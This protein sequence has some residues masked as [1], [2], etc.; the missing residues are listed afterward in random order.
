MFDVLL[1]F[2]ER[3]KGNNDRNLLVQIQ[4]VR[5]HFQTILVENAQFMLFL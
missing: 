2:V 1:F 3:G 4:L 5:I